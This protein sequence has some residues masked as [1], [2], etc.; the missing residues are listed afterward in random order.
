MRDV[1]RYRWK[2]EEGEDRVRTIVSCLDLKGD[3]EGEE[4]LTGLRVKRSGAQEQPSV[5]LNLNRLSCLFR[6]LCMGSCKERRP[7][8]VA[9]A[10]G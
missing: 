2:R 5:I 1:P 7:V 10:R 6:G 3:K 9:Q 8:P 4:G